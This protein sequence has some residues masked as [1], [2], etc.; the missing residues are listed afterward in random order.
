MGD[1]RKKVLNITG[2]NNG[3]I[4]INPHKDPDNL[5]INNTFKVSHTYNNEGLEDSIQ[6]SNRTGNIFI[7]DQSDGYFK[8]FYVNNNEFFIEPMT[9]GIYNEP[10]RFIESSNLQTEIETLS[11][12]NTSEGALVFSNIYLANEGIINFL[13]TET[14]PHDTSI[15]SGFKV[16]SGELSFKNSGDSSWTALTTSVGGATNLNQLS[17]VSLSTRVNNQVLLYDSSSSVFRNSNIVIST[18]T[19]PIL[20]GNLVVGSFNMI[21]NNE[22]KGLI[23]STGNSIV[24][25]SNN[26]T[27]DQSYVLFQHSSAETPEIKVEGSSSDI[28]MVI[29]SKGTGDIDINSSNLD[30]NSSNVNLTSLTNL[31]FSSGFIQKSINT[32]NSLSTNIGS[33][34]SLSSSYNIILFNISG[35]NN[36]Y[37]AT[38]ADG[39]NGQC[40]DIIY[41][42]SGSNNTI[43]ISFNSKV[44]TGTGLYNTLTFTTSGQASSLVYLGNLGSRNRWQVLN[45]GA[46]IN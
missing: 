28:D 27:T 39:S 32:V 14:P 34:T 17:D 31:S 9:D 15:I 23:D 21:F 7:K 6:D 29:S 33:P 12:D 3:N 46:L 13:S 4:F 38:L 19:N 1:T 2:D 40:L 42:T 35:N 18:D 26:N 24:R 36:N 44:G 30:I 37:Y 45:T 43:N 16:E 22:S 8:R 25:I 20:G 11:T 5:L 41:D 10:V